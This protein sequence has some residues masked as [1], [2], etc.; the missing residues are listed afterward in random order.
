MKRC[1]LKFTHPTPKTCEQQPIRHPYFDIW[2]FKLAALGDFRVCT[3]FVENCRVV[4]PAVHVT[5]SE[6]PGN[7][8]RAWTRLRFFVP[9]IV[10]YELRRELLRAGKTAYIRRLD[11]FVAAEYAEVSFPFERFYSRIY[12]GKSHAA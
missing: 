1:V 7:R 11:A 10:D 6:K 8:T 3:D 2:P 12:S 4:S 5:V 9:A